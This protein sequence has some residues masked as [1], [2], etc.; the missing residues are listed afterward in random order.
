MKKLTLLLIIFV[1]I[2]QGY[3]QTTEAEDKLKAI[4][5]VG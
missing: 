2:V 4:E 1:P 5:N 3:S